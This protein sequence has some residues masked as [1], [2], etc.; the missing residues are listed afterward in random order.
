M[1]I[2]VNS[3]LVKLDAF[4]DFWIPESIA[5][6]KEM[7]QRARMFLLSH[8][9]GP[10][11]GNALPLFMLVLGFPADHKLLIF[12]GSITLF[13]VFPPLLK[14]GANYTML[15]F[16]SIQNLIFVILWACY[17]YGGVHSPFLP[18]IVAIPLL[19]FFYLSAEGAQKYWIAAV[20]GGN[21][22]AF[23][24]LNFLGVLTFPPADLASLQSPGMLSMVSSCTYV[25]MM[26]LYYAKL[27]ASQSDLEQEAQKHLAT[28]DELRRITAAARRAGAAK[29]EFVAKMSHELRTPLN[30]VIGYSQILLE[31]AR[32][33]GDK[34]AMVDLDRIQVAGQHLLR[35]VNDVLDYSKIDAGK[36]EPLA[37]EVS[38]RNNLTAMVDAYQEAA[39]RNGSVIRMAPG[40]PISQVRL[41]WSLAQKAV[42]HVIGNAVKFTRNGE[43][44]VSCVLA[45]GFLDITVRDTGPGIESQVLPHIFNA[46]SVPTDISSSK[47]G[48]AG[49]GLALSN[50]ICTLLGGGISVESTLGQ[51][52]TFTITLPVTPPETLANAA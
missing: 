1:A 17:C 34:L 45:A 10:F 25:A 47:Y 6:Q 33:E 28:A 52:A 51:G 32:L 14:Y 11:L 29:S 16:A 46:F 3:A 42:N 20:I 22:V 48:G 31:D 24:G 7:R 40:P 43:I 2:S 23:Y 44:E 39:A 12:A 18:W 19:A 4:L 37:S 21:L 49:L 35:L 27:Q 15:A 5:S 36:M 38:I 8:V 41:D 9:M 13:W 30:A 26:A 50:R